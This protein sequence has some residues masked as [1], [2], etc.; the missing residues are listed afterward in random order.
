[1]ARMILLHIDDNECADAILNTPPQGSR[2]IGLYFAPT[3]FCECASVPTKD[4]YLV[5]SAFPRGAKYGLYI[6]NV[7]HKPYRGSHHSP[8]NL[9]VERKYARS[10]LS[11]G[12]KFP[13]DPAVP[14]DPF[15]H[16][17]PNHRSNQSR[18]KK[19]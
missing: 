13:Y 1:M 7:C 2:V 16:P 17:D 6:H 8:Q 9:L 3:Q 15:G 5:N 4:G 19:H 12:I 14:Y 10:N 11:L 18:R